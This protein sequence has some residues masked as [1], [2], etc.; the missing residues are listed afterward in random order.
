M[1]Q[2]L[3]I[4]DGAGHGRATWDY[5]HVVGD[6]VFRDRAVEGLTRLAEL[7]AECRSEANGHAGSCGYNDSSFSRFPAFAGTPVRACVSPS[8]VAGIRWLVGVTGGVVCGRF[9][10]TAEHCQGETKTQ[11]K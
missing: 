7:R 5:N 4:G 6:D 11:Y 10:G 9:A 8:R 2:S 1:T 3:G